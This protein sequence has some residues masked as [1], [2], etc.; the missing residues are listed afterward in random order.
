[1]TTWFPEVNEEAAIW[2]GLAT[3]TMLNGLNHKTEN[4]K[5]LSNSE[6]LS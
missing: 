3:V 5:Y 2:A 6:A 4:M 1:V